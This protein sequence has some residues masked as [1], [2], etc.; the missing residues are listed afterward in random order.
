MRQVR[1]VQL[2]IILACVGVGSIGATLASP[3]QQD[4]AP[5]TIDVGE[6]IRIDLNAGTGT[7]LDESGFGLSCEDGGAVDFTVSGAGTRYEI[8][9]AQP[10]TP[11]DTCTVSVFVD[12]AADD[13]FLVGVSMTFT[14]ADEA[15]SSTSDAA[16]TVTVDA[17]PESTV[18][19]SIGMVQGSGATFAL[20]GVQTIRGIV[21]LD[22]ED[23]GDDSTLDVRGFYV[24]DAGDGDP[25]TS[26][27][28]L[29]FTNATESYVEVGDRVQVTGTVME[30][31][32]QGASE[33]QL[34]ADGADIVV[35]SSGNP[36]PAPVEV[37]LPFADADAPERY[38]GMLVTFP[39]ALT[40]T[41]IYQLG[42]HSELMLSS[43]G[44]LQQPTNVA[45]PGAD[46]QAVAEANLLNR[47][48]IDD[49]NLTE[50][51]DPIVFPPPELTAEN[52]VRGGYTVTGLTGVFTQS[53]A[54]VSNNGN[55]TITYRVRVTAPPTF[56]SA[57]N[58]RPTQ[59]P[60]VGAAA[61][62]AASFNLLNYFNSFSI[63]PS[64]CFQGGFM[65]AAYCRGAN[66]PFEFER[67]HAK[68][69][70][71]LAALDAD[72]VG[73]V[74][75]EN[76]EGDDQAIAA[77]VAGVNAI[78]G[79]GT[80]A[81]IDT[82][83]VGTDA[84]RNGFI[85]KPAVV[86]PV[87]G[88]AAL[89]D[90]EPFTVNTR[91]PLAQLWREVAS[92]EQF[93]VVVNHLKSKSTSG[94]PLRGDNA[95]ENDGQGCWNEDRLLAASLTAGW[96]ADDPYFTA[97]PDVLLVGDFNSYAKE[98]PITYLIANGYTD[99]VAQFIGAD[100]YS[101]VF[102]GQWGYLDYALANTALLPQIAGAAEF[103]INADEPGFLD[104]NVEYKSERHIDLL[105]A[106]NMYR[107][108]DHD[109]V[110]VGLHLGRE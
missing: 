63:T 24:Q 91:P 107:V 38:E 68:T 32:R 42:R 89:D 96:I 31:P 78:A 3:T 80:Y 9:P 75:L 71:A 4:G 92:G 17:C 23:D 16:P 94:C 90:V 60:D 86:V 64:G 45:L 102:D 26:D 15:A 66:S 67:Q 34:V 70:A 100:A 105:Y 8:T 95:D 43:G 93:Y 48:A 106:P 20:S 13:A 27:G 82:G 103:H 49:T 10:L 62:T 85:Y 50:D 29:V 6:S 69:T 22:M 61:L 74:E 44:R 52:T 109:P 79:E 18:G 36:L 28:I 98:D 46:A 84:I 47:I 65:S 7:R 11:G 14:V 104:Y 1:L 30:F 108:G 58:P 59:A 19:T 41:E 35:C 110:L 25:A 87:G 2:L 73:L 88:F 39:Q 83:R 33:T 99:A 77:L 53:R 12:G 57:P 81:F 72:I 76:D 37:T 56:D 51:P 5:V 101:Y 55:T 54:R 40:V 21:T 97:D